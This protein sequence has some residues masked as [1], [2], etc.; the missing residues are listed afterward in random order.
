MDLVTSV[1]P[2]IGDQHLAHKPFPS[3]IQEN[4]GPG[5]LEAHHALSCQ[6]SMLFPPHP[7]LVLVVLVDTI[8]S[9]G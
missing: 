2:N 5:D 9:F 4:R 6:A 8:L 1:A 3:P 7:N